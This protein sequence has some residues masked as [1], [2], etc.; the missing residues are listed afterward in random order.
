MSDAGICDARL[1]LLHPSD[2]VLIARIDL[3]AGQAL[4]VDGKHMILRDAIPIGHKIARSALAKGEKILRYG[5]PIGTLSA[6][7]ERGAHVHGHN[8]DSD[9]LPAHSRHGVSRGR[10]K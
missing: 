5:A 10:I 9:Y 4:E 1:L 6:P 8:L 2:N 7:V 3:H